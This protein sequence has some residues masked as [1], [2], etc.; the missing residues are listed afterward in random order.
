MVTAS[1]SL[2][3]D[4]SLSFLSCGDAWVPVADGA[5]VDARAGADV[6][7]TDGEG[8]VSA[9]GVSSSARTNRAIDMSLRRASLFRAG[10][11]VG[12]CLAV[13]RG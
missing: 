2:S 9:P 12:D 7:S 6:G 11:V 5:G 4:L 13:R 10:M 8:S 3:P 1:L